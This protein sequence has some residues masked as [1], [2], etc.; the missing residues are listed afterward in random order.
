MANHIIYNYTYSEY[1]CAIKILKIVDSILICR[2]LKIVIRRHLIGIGIEF[3]INLN[4]FRTTILV[5]SLSKY[6][7]RKDLKLSVITY[8][9]IL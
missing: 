8:I 1:R 9:I 3:Q 4:I 6:I 5:I 7:I 2:L